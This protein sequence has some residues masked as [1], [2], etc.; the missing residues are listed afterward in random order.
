MRPLSI[1]AAL[2]IALALIATAYA[3]PV[4]MRASGEA[5]ITVPHG[6]MQLH[7]D[8]N[9]FQHDMNLEVNTPGVHMDIN[10]MIKITENGVQVELNHHVYHLP[11]PNYAVAGIKA[12]LNRYRIRVE[13]NI[14]QHLRLGVCQVFDQNTLQYVEEPCYKAPLKV[15]GHLLGIIPVDFDAEA[16]CT[17]EANQLMCDVKTPWWAFLVFGQTAET[18]Q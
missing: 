2:I 4:N 11:H 15:R 12:A 10:R 17:M 8:L 14:E 3:Y 1:L 16:Q 9:G 18:A 5:V 6:G 13:A 7:V